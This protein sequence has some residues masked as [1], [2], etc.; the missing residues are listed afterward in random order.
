MPGALFLAVHISALTRSDASMRRRATG[1]M[2]ASGPRRSKYGIN[3]S[4]RAM[5]TAPNESALI[6]NTT[7][8][9]VK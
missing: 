6:V 3:P 1:A 9:E 7:L 4:S 2:R 8:N 5:M